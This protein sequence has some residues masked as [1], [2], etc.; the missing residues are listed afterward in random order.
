M[1]TLLDLR[2]NIPSFIH[3][4]DGKLG[5]KGNSKPRYVIRWRLGRPR[6]DEVREHALFVFTGAE[7]GLGILGMG[8]LTCG[9]PSGKEFV[10]CGGVHVSVCSS[11]SGCWNGS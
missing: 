8:A 3:I 7:C 6:F 9:L 10:E 4:S 5:D 11:F 2:G 1:H